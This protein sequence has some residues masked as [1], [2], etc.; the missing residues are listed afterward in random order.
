MAKTSSANFLLSLGGGQYR[1]VALRGRN[2]WLAD[3]LIAVGDSG[4]TARDCPPGLR[5]AAHVLKL[6]GV[7][8]PI[9]ATTERHGGEHA[10]WHSR[11]R[12]A[13][14]ATLTRVRGD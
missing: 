14:G 12:I 3:R 9:E 13:S 1:P 2:A 8:I 6:R 10:G 7:G 4:L 11:Y 5:L